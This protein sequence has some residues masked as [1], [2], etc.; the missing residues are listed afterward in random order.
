RFRPGNKV[1][2]RLMPRNTQYKKG[3]IIA[4]K[5]GDNYPFTFHEI[6]DSYIYNGKTFYITGG[7][8]PD[9]NQY[10][11][12]FTIP[13]EKILGYAEISENSLS[14]T[15]T[16]EQQGVLIYV[17]AHASTNQFDLLHK[18]LIESQQGIKNWKQKVND[19]SKEELLYALTDRM[20][21]LCKDDYNGVSNADLLEEMRAKQLK[22]CRD[23]IIKYI[24][25]DR[26]TGL[27][28]R[29]AE[30]FIKMFDNI[31]GK[32]ISSNNLKEISG[33]LSVAYKK[34]FALI[35][36]LLCS[37]NLYTLDSII[38]ELNIDVDSLN[39]I[40]NE[41]WGR[42]LSI[43]NYNQ[44]LKNQVES[45]MEQFISTERFSN[46][47][48]GISEN[49][50]GLF[51]RGSETMK[52][53]VFNRDL[54]LSE[55]NIG[56][57]KSLLDAELVE[58]LKSENPSQIGDLQLEQYDKMLEALGI[59]KELIDLTDADIM[60]IARKR[61]RWGD[62]NDGKDSGNV[63]YKVYKIQ[64]SDGRIETGVLFAWSKA[65]EM[66]GITKNPNENWNQYA[67][68]IYNEKFEEIYKV[69]KTPKNFIQWRGW[70]SEAKILALFLD[71]IANQK[72]KIYNF[73]FTLASEKGYC[74]YC[75]RSI[76]NFI[77]H[78]SNLNNLAFLTYL[79][80]NR[81]GDDKAGG[82]RGYQFPFIDTNIF[83]Y[84]VTYY[85]WN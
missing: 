69:L 40:I 27:P 64:Y 73:E 23:F 6:V 76:N 56:I 32:E 50:D 26:S 70:D 62:W 42:E 83:Y 78:V 51:I 5:P 46:V 11:D 54:T 57:L 71:K 44:L 74:F 20:I 18:T 66:F 59:D 75:D 47:Y 2:V 4:F 7:L 77:T 68:R 39:E 13:A 16:L 45:Q 15:Q 34:M 61:F 84:G 49:K 80:R 9:T 29:S 19:V 17:P 36:I 67:Q 22:F 81:A 8:N 30:L 43:T 55:V 58:I 21:T 53:L 28:T 79:S 14:G 63:A 35:E 1:P 25:S 65:Q 38:Q 33:D 37:E 10:V 72:D 3:D 82:V 12:S 24:F 41:I 31:F 52:Q 85:N 48:D 60:N